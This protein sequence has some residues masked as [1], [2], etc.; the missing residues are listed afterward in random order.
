MVLP[1]QTAKLWRPTINGKDVFETFEIE[2]DAALLQLLIDDMGGFDRALEKVYL[3]LHYRQKSKRK[4][5]FASVL[6]CVV[7][8]VQATYPAVDFRVNAMSVAFMAVVTRRTVADSSRFGNSGLDEVMPLGLLR[9][10]NRRL[11]C[12]YVL[13]LLLPP[14]LFGPWYTYV[15]SEKREQEDWKPW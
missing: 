11:E 10:R 12:P 1:V 6:H 3:V 7:R 2:M 4:L 14:E 13:Y 9:L 15:P 8:D 5:E